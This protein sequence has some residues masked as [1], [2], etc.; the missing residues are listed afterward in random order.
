MYSR[1]EI[2]SIKDIIQEGCLVMMGKSN[3]RIKTTSWCLMTPH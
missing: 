2:Y 1:K 3:S